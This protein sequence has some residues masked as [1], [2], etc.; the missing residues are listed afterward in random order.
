MIDRDPEKVALVVRRLL[1][2]APSATPENALLGAMCPAF[3]EDLAS[4]VDA[5]KAAVKKERSAAGGK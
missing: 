4:V 2:A 1:H 3:G 5:W